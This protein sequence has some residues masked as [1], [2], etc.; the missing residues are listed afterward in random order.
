MKPIRSSHE[1]NAIEIQPK[2]FEDL[3]SPRKNTTD[4]IQNDPVNL[5]HLLPPRSLISTSDLICENG[6]NSTCL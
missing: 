2:P 3:V 5:Q 1:T 6:K 4:R